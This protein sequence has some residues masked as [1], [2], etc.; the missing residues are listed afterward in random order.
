MGRSLLAVTDRIC[1]AAWHTYHHV[2]NYAWD[3]ATPPN[4]CPITTQESNAKDDRG[5]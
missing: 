3:R 2:T 4:D 5:I 1:K